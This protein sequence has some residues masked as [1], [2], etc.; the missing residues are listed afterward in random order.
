MP[1]FFLF[2]FSLS[3]LKA[4]L[5][6]IRPQVRLGARAKYD[7]VIAVL[8]EVRFEC[9]QRLFAWL[10][11][12]F[13]TFRTALLPKMHDFWVIIAERACLCRHLCETEAV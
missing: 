7:A 5:Y 4:D 8:A 9:A 12:F 10:C 1:L 11:A 6:L 2:C 13:F 3:L